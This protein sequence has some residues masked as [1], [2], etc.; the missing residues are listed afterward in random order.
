MGLRQAAA[1]GGTCRK[2]VLLKHMHCGQSGSCW[3]ALLT[4]RKYPHASKLK[5]CLDKELMCVCFTLSN[6]FLRGISM[7]CSASNI[8]G[9]LCRVIYFSA[10]HNTKQLFHKVQRA[11]CQPNHVAPAPG[12]AC[13]NLQHNMNLA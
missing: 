5:I 2:L 3:H 10:C 9:R 8:S 12:Q 13:S 6:C 1:G 11:H 4:G 7:V